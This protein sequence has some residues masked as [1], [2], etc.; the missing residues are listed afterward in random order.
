MCGLITKRARLNE[1]L[2]LCLFADTFNSNPRVTTL[3]F[4]KNLLET[5]PPGMFRK[6]K[7]MQRIDLSYNLIT[8]LSVEVG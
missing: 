1:W 7:G 8:T 4:T 5:I 3:N 2:S 6:L